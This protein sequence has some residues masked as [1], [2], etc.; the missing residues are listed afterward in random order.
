M[1]DWTD[2][3]DWIDWV[4]DCLGDMIKDLYNQTM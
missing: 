1:A 4:Y 2:W 3:T